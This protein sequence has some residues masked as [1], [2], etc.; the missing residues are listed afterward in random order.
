MASDQGV[1]PSISIDQVSAT[2]AV[3]G[4]VAESTVH[5]VSPQ[6][7]RLAII[8]KYVVAPVEVDKITA[9]SS[10]GNVATASRPNRIAI[11]ATRYSVIAISTN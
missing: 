6:I 2:T 8:P 1:I 10:I 11:H 3:D 9:K 7:A 4:V 5:R